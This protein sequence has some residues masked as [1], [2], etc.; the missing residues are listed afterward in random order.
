MQKFTPADTA[1][2]LIFGGPY[3]NLA[4]TQAIKEISQQLDIPTG[5][6]LCTGDIV[7]YCASPQETTDVIHEWGISVVQG[8]CE[9]SLGNDASDCG[10]GF[11]TGSSCDLLSAGWFNFAKPR[12]SADAKAWMASLPAHISFDW[13]GLTMHAIH[14]G[15][16]SINQFI[17]ASDTAEQTQQQ[18]DSGG[19][20]IISG[21]C[22]IPFGRILTN[23]TWL[24]AG[25]I[26]MP[27]N[28]GQPDTWYMLITPE[29]DGR[30]TA[31]WH[32]L[33]YDVQDSIS[34]MHQAGLN[35]P[36]ADALNTGYWPSTDI[37]PPAEQSATGQP[38]SLSPLPLSPGIV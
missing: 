3:S 7:A 23:G 9:E 28:D 13:A 4:A 26:G 22:G 33:Q 19:D 25:V 34:K 1:P 10:C 16:N 15:L 29:A 12:V 17:F 14:G 36:Y 30:I 31:S 37:L 24:N 32:A 27:A 20:V 21:H 35:T 5:N 18:A 8:N 2:L 11:D 6:I 38:L